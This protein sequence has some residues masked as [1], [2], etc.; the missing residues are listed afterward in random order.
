MKHALSLLLALLLCAEGLSAVRGENTMRMKINDTSVDVAW[1][2]NASVQA[3]RELAAEGL[4]VRM[5]M[6]GGFEQVGAIGQSLPREDRQTV[7]APGDIV[8][9]S[10][11]QIV[12]FYGSNSW[13]YTRLGHITDRSPEQMRELLG[14]GDVTITLSMGE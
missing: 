12:V 13:A 14:N 3:L 8:L 6:Y 10:G 5:S 2:E 4:T 11:D 1:E 7:T 9:Y